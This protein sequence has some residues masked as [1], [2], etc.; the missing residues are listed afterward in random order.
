MEKAH[1][2][3]KKRYIQATTRDIQNRDI[4]TIK[5]K[6]VTNTVLLQTGTACDVHYSKLRL[7]ARAA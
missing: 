7:Y 1:Q 6:S 4:V 2:Q 3:L 5:G